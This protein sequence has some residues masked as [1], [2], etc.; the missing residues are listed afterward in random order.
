[1]AMNE[2]KELFAKRA[3]AADMF[4]E[5]KGGLASRPEGFVIYLSTMSDEAPAGV[6]ADLLKRA[7][8]VRDGKRVDNRL[9]PVLYE[10]PKE[11]LDSGTYR[12]PENFY[13]TNPNMGASVS[14]TYLMGEFE[15]A[16]ADGEIALRRFMAKH[17]NVQI[18]L[19]LTAD[20]W[21]GAEFWEE[22]GNRPEINLDWMLEHC[23]VIDIGVDGGGLDDL[24]GISA[25]GR[26]KDNPRM[27]AA[28]FHAWAHPSV[29]ERR[30]EIA[31]VLL[32]FAKQGDLTI[33]HR[34]GDDS[35]EVAGVVARVYQ[36]GLLDKCG[37]DPHGVGAILDAML[38]YGVPEDAVVGVSQ[39]WK[40]GAAIT[41][42]VIV[43]SPQGE[44][45]RMGEEIFQR[46]LPEAVNCN[47]SIRY[48]NPAYDFLLDG[49]RIDIKCSA[50]SLAK[51]GGNR[52]VFPFNI[53]NAL[54]TDCFV[55]IVKTEDG[56]E[57]I[58]ESYR[59]CFIIPSLFLISTHRLIIG[60]KAVYDGGMAWHEFCYPIEKMAEKVRQIAANKEAFAIP[61]GLKQAAEAHREL[62]TE[63]NKKGKK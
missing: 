56:S 12:L 4:T 58:P 10:F 35:D 53:K 48:A 52:R 6:F 8:E 1:M 5:A 21:A 63:I 46:H 27:W 31:P 26:L 19:S 43:N 15:T 45:G 57:N 9:L 60:D 14:E 37:L 18:S 17:L 40:L 3:K 33:V 2:Q 22:N 28:W 44:Q 16:K 11:M 34:I 23:E 51:K 20:Y 13:I 61:E 29:L 24:L 47:T 62:K 25:V 36:S 30:K 38:E 41:E 39:G 42:A 59:H 32:D 55:F 50:G 7:R 54:K 49:L